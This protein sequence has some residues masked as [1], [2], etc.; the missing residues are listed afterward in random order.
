MLPLTKSIEFDNLCK[1]LVIISKKKALELKPKPFIKVLSTN[2]P[3]LK[4][5]VGITTPDGVTAIDINVATQNLQFYGYTP[6]TPK[7]GGI[8]RIIIAESC[9]G[10]PTD[11][12]VQNKAPVSDTKVKTEVKTKPKLRTKPVTDKKSGKKTLAVRFG[13]NFV[14]GEY[15]FTLVMSLLMPVFL[16]FYINS[17]WFICFS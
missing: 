16:A 13:P 14:R 4:N 11:K 12:N 2:I 3:N 9:P 10:T 17:H 15:I 8:V 6:D 5:L 1:R 7:I